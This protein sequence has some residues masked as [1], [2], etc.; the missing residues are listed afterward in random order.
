[1]AAFQVAMEIGAMDYS[2]VVAAMGGDM[3]T[4]IAKRKRTMA[5][6]QTAGLPPVPYWTPRGGASRTTQVQGT[7]LETGETTQFEV[8]SDELAG[9]EA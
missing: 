4:L 2:D 5:M 8:N 6:L 7:D 9:A 3:Q 1:M